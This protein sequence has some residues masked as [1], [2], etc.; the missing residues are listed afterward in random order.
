[1]ELF[2]FDGLILEGLRRGASDVHIETGFKPHFRI[3]GDVIES[4]FGASTHSHIEDIKSLVLNEDALF[5]LDKEHAVD[6]AYTVKENG[7][8]A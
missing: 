3:D 4:D 1:M 6:R 8:P 5:R 7:T 2:D